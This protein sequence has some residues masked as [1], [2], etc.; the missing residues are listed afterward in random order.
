MRVRLRRL[1]EAVSGLIEDLY[2]RGLDKDVM[3]IVSGEFG[4]T[5]QLNMGRAL[6]PKWPGRDHWPGAMSVLVSG[7]GMRTGQVIG[8]TTS[9]AEVPLE[10]AL[11]PNDLLASIY[12]FLGI[13]PDH[14]FPDFR[15]RPMP[16]LTHGQPIAELG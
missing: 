10:R 2:E 11:E 9:R 8:A 13:N 1:D 12:R 7:G 6:V 3:V 14:A 4:R 16:I 15:G 5:P